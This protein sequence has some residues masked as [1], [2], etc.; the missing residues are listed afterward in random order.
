VEV[1]FS[2]ALSVAMTLCRGGLRA[3]D[4][5]ETS[6]RAVSADVRALAARTDVEHDLAMTLDLLDGLDRALALRRFVAAL[7]P[8]ALWR[9]A[10][11]LQDDLSLGQALRPRLGAGSVGAVARALWTG[12]L[13]GG[14]RRKA[15]D[16]GTGGDAG[17]YDFGRA[18][19]DVL[20]FRFSAAVE[21]ELQDGT[22]LQATQRI[23]RAAPGWDAADTERLV[24]EK[25]LREAAP[26]LG[27][28]RA[29]A[30]LAAATDP[31]GDARPASALLADLS[32][33]E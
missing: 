4:F 2:V 12:V 16:G 23:P 28:A 10:R 3:A 6:L 20:E 1:N 26:V 8:R 22:V 29:R 14:G 31:A 30:A 15:H 7:G 18:Q 11:R 24:H 21:V 13:G 27:E 25:F 32:A 33:R 19:L 9:A 17:P 5:A